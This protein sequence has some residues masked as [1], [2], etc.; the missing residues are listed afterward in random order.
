[1]L[2]VVNLTH[3][4]LQTLVWIDNSFSCYWGTSFLQVTLRQKACIAGAS[5]CA[6]LLW[7]ALKVRNQLPTIVSP[8]FFLCMSWSCTTQ[9][10]DSYF[11]QSAIRR[12][13]STELGRQKGARHRPMSMQWRCGMTRDLW[14]AVRYLLLQLS[15]LPWRLAAPPAHPFPW[16]LAPAYHIHMLYIGVS[17]GTC[18]HIF[19]AA[20]RG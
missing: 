18:S 9:Q 7:H 13:I 12:F 14:E 5:P 1:M 17:N 6:H 11:R 3:E 16:P 2:S 20:C 15:A 4:S 8:F 19:H 10:W